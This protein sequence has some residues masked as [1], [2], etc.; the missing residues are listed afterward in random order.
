[1]ALLN[2]SKMQ[3]IFNEIFKPVKLNLVKI[4]W[5]FTELNEKQPKFNEFKIFQWHFNFYKFWSHN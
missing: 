5:A 4:F 1:M 3:Q 2:V